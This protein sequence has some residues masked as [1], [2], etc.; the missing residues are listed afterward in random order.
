MLRRRGGMVSSAPAFSSV[1]KVRE[2]AAIYVYCRTSRQQDY[3]KQIL[4]G[5]M[6]HSC[7]EGAW[8]TERVSRLMVQGVDGRWDFNTTGN[9]K[10][11]RELCRSLPLSY[12]FSA[13]VPGQ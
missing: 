11:T 3:S 6:A 10:K 2:F 13:L 12:F 1:K 5:S 8:G 7:M 4:T 9:I